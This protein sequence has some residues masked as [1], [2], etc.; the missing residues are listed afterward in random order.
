MTTTI[1][2]SNTMIFMHWMMLVLVAS[3]FAF[4]ELRELFP[5]G[6][7]PRNLMKFIH[8]SL[9]FTVLACVLCRLYFKFTSNPPVAHLSIAAKLGHGF[10]YAFL[11]MMP[12]LGWL[13]LSAEGKDI[14]FFAFSL[15]AL[16]AENQAL[17][18]TFEEWHETLGV[19]GYW[20][21]GGH[22]LMALYHHYI[23]K[24]PIFSRIMP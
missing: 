23:K 12:I 10:L 9:G 14:P 1:K 21:I 11:I 17:A 15:P 13:T 8:F 19:V 20:A 16:I 5:K 6:T 2:Y 4:I 7:D 24:D 18:H 3:T 22:A